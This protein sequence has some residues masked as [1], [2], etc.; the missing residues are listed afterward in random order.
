M[1][2]ILA[3]VAGTCLASTAFAQTALT[4]DVVFY[5][6]DS[7][8]NDWGI[9]RHTD[10]DGDGLFLSAG[11][12]NPF[13]VDGQ[14]QINYVQDL[15]YRN[16]GGTDYLYVIST[17]DMVLRLEDI[18]G[19]G[20][21]DGAGEIVEWA[22]TRAGG[23]F[24][25]TSPDALDY[26]DVTG[27]MYVTD[28]NY[29]SGPQP[30]SGIHA[31]TDNNLD[32]DA[33]DSGEYMQF[34]DANLAITVA[35]T[36]G[37]VTIDA[38]D[39]EGLMVDDVNGFVVGW[40]KQDSVLYAFQDLNGDGDANDAGEAWN[41]CNLAGDMPGLEQNA[42]VVAGTLHNP[43]CPSSSGTGLYSPFAVLDF[44]PGAGPAGE[45][46]Y[47]LMSTA[48]ASCIGANGQVYRG[49]DL[50]GDLDLNDAGE[51]T[52]FFDGPNSGVAVPAI[53]GGAAH[54][55]GYSIRVNG[56]DVFFL[57]DIDGNG[58]AMGGT[59][60]VQTGFD[61][62]SHFVGEMEAIPAGAFAPPVSGSFTVFGTAGTN[63]NGGTPAIG[64]IG[65]P[66][67][68]QPFSIT[69][70]DGIGSL[71]ATLYLGFSN[72]TWNRPPLITLPFDMTGIGAPGNTLYVPG[73]FQFNVTCDA[74]GNATLN[75]AVPNNPSLAGSDVYVQ[76][77]C[78]DIFANPRGVTMSNAAHMVVGQ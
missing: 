26:D 14:T 67:V 57:E 23:G 66:A 78:T 68:G 61:P 50:N 16:E 36:G 42:D 38:G 32:G 22:D 75:L 4:H 6:G 77:Y 49:I 58:D 21:V 63:S 3:I 73:E 47:W 52:Q 65:V 20:R 56:G 44:A 8:L 24:S 7:V 37:P 30:G 31:Y 39:F 1:R 76:W 43:S 55:G 19:D 12:L 18:D 45:D 54:D 41:F 71:P 35:G 40:A 70:T 59:E 69:L 28:D 51:V 48:S 10:V 2:N 53:Y 25:N 33:N 60:A 74:S 11:E 13:G 72:T 17:N 29:S 27:T 64:N 62:L 9:Y 15:R 5:Q 34:V 46:V